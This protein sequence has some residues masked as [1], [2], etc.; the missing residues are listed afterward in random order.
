MN[1]FF[2]SSDPMLS[3][4]W[5]EESFVWLGA[6]VKFFAYLYKLTLSTSIAIFIFKV[7]VQTQAINTFDTPVK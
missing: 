6:G 3:C 5:R 7:V 1:A 4:T 2:W